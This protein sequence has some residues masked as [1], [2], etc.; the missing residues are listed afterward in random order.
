MSKKKSDEKVEKTNQVDE[1]PGDA[2]QAE[3]PSINLNDL[4]QLRN[5]VDVAAT[6][7][8]FRGE[9]LS[10]VGGVRDRLTAFLD[11]ALPPAEPENKG[12]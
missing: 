3:A 8:A 2:P 1:T 12:E 6:R 7:G 5:I 9:E 4:L 11:H 10:L